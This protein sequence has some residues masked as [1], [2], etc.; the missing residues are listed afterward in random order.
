M[1]RRWKKPEKSALFQKHE[2]QLRGLA[3]RISRKTGIPFDDLYGPAGEA[4]C[5]AFYA[6]EPGKAQFS[7]FLH[8]VVTNNLKNLVD[9]HFRERGKT[10]P[11]LDEE[12]V[13]EEPHVEDRICFLEALENLSP[14]ARNVAEAV[15]SAPGEFL[16]MPVR[17]IRGTLRKQL[18]EQGYK[19]QQ[20]LNIFKEIKEAVE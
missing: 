10:V 20:I 3:G 6:F 11:L 7:T 17:T 8:T 15:L 9:K 14:E 13:W 1:K 18:K 5:E 4:F 16:E 12:M 2:K 19:P